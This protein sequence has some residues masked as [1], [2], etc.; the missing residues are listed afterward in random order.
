MAYLFVVDR[1]PGRI[2]IRRQLKWESADEIAS[3]LNEVCLERGPVEEL[4]M[5]NAT[6]FRSEL[7]KT[8]LDNW[9]VQWFFRAEYHPSGNG[10]AERHHRTIKAMAERGSISPMETVFWYN[11]SPRAG[12]AKNFVPERAVFHYRWRHPTVQLELKDHDKE[13]TVE[14][15]EEVWVKPANAR[16]TALW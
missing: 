3:I 7:L 14:V 10:I 16:C 12:Q 11:V 9:S 5:D 13:T 6:V 2:A 1:W 15:G 4:L 8:A